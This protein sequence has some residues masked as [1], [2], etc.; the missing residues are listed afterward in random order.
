MLRLRV[1]AVPRA[2][3]SIKHTREAISVR[4]KTMKTRNEI[5]P[6]RQR[7]EDTYETFSRETV[8]CGRAGACVRSKI[9]PARSPC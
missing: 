9:T 7:A 2:R 1:G 6:R 5:G 3:S 4:R 8:C